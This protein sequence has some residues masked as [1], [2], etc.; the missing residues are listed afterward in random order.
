MPERLYD[1]NKN[2]VQPEQV[3]HEPHNMLELIKMMPG[4]INRNQG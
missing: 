2:V 1:E 4:E 3:N